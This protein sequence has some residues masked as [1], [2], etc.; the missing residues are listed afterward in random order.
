[1]TLLFAQAGS[2]ILITLAIGAAILLG[3]VVLMAL[4]FA[5]FYRKVGPEEAIVRSGQ[6]GLRAATGSGIFV[7]PI[8]HRADHMDLSVKR[9]EIARRGEAGLICKDN[10]RADIEVAFFVRVNNTRDDILAVAQS[11][12]CRR[13]SAQEALDELFNAKF[14]EALKTVGKQFDFVELFLERDKFKQKILAVIGTDLNGYVLDDCA[15][16]YLEQTPVA[17]LDPQNIL[18]AEGIK[19]ITQLTAREHMIANEITREKEKTIKKQDV[20]AREAI[21][22]LEKQQADAEER[23]AREIAEITAR[24][25][26]QSDVVR[27]EERLKAESARIRTEEEIRVA[28]ENR[29]RQI[30]VAQRNKERTDGVELERV[31]RDRMLEATERER[32]VGVA[33]V[34]R[35]KAIEIERRNIQDVI[36]ERVVVERAVVEEQERIK[37]TSAFAGAERQKKVTVTAAEEQAQQAL[38]KEVKAAEAAKQAATLKADQLVIEAEAQRAAAEK[39]MLSIKM[40]AEAKTAD[41]AAPG[42]AEAHVLAAKADAIEKEGTAQ[43]NV[44]QKKL[45]AEAKGQE[46]KAIAIEKEGTAEANVLRLKLSS[47][48][49]GIEDKA[50]AMKLFDSVGK[51]HEEFKLRLEKDKQ[52]EIAAIEA[53]IPI[54]EAQSKIVGE[55]M[56]SAR[57]DIVGGESEFFERVVNSV[58]GGKVVDRFFDNSQVLSDVK[59]TFFN[60]NPEYFRDRMRSIVQELNL[61]TD[62]IKDLSIAALIGKMIGVAE[63]E[64]VRN[65]LGKLLS[66]AAQAGLIDERASM[67]KLGD[68]GVT[69]KERVK[70]S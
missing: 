15:I 63:S 14:S 36:R 51:E 53:Q 66:L 56:K 39:E 41:V 49:K 11:L 64:A 50:E 16:D 12:G 60:G 18:D 28:E 5:R 19:K 48:A 40:L 20:E 10:I 42:L 2:S 68:D 29:D 25:R 44:I 30:L 17:K 33:Q 52:I 65:E 38:V 31:Q 13:A 61:S 21:L 58:K 9:I 27:E 43:A 54:A 34:E 57:I 32:V 55:A 26:S 3:L 59:N 23:Q 24:Q 8:L 22:E 45:T 47:E 70:K 35:E 6:G 62:S 69:A 37:D 4:M 7:I 46:A 67:L 1:M